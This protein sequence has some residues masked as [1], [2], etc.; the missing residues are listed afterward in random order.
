MV[1][2]A[3]PLQLRLVTVA[4]N[5]RDACLCLSP[6]SLARERLSLRI[7]DVRSPPHARRLAEY[8]LLSMRIGIPCF[9]V[10]ATF[11]SLTTDYR[12]DVCAFPLCKPFRYVLHHSVFIFVH[13]Y[14]ER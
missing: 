11:A 8:G 10:E 12:W 1:H 4:H 14:N 5:G 3:A 9:G 7:W 2:L 13:G 6:A